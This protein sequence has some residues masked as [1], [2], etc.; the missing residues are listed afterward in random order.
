MP[1]RAESSDVSRLH[2][3]IYG[4]N[5]YHS[6]R[7]IAQMRNLRVTG[8]LIKLEHTLLDLL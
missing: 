3:T 2:A 8:F 7:N 5:Y 4:I 6:Y 1:V